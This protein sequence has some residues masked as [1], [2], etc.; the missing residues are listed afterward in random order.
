MQKKKKS[1][2]D[3][4]PLNNLPYYVSKGLFP[5]LCCPKHDLNHPFN[6]SLA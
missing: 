4:F 2:I 6:E 1:T 3:F 5:V